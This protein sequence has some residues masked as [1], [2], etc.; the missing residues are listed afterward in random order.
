MSL[1]GP[2]TMADRVPTFLVNVDGVGA[3]QA[4]RALAERGIG[5]WYADNWYCVGLTDRLPEQSLR[6]GFAHYNTAGEVD[7][8][9]GELAAL[10]R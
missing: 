6:I 4:A 8:L 7:R 9:V 5:V 10:A 2:P 3:E 1:F